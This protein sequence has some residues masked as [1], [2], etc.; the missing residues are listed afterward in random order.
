MRALCTSVDPKIPCQLKWLNEYFYEDKY[1]R[2]Y[3]KYGSVTY[4]VD[5]DHA[6]TA[7]WVFE[8]CSGR[9]AQNGK[10]LYEGDK[11]RAILS[12]YGIATQGEIVFD[13]KR[14]CFANK[15]D[16]G[17]TP[18]YDFHKIEIIG[19][20]HENPESLEER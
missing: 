15:N 12:D 16:I 18:L 7:G 14:S 11:I 3:K 19:N 8:L 2:F 4:Y 10:L 9:K 5:K 20:I 1:G 17:N 6:V 13:E